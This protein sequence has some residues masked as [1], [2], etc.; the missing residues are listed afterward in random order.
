LWETP[1]ALPS[2]PRTWWAWIRCCMW[3]TMCMTDPPDDEK[4][5]IFQ[6]PEFIKKMLEKGYL[7]EKTRQGF[8]KKSKDADGKRV[9]LSLDYKSLDY[10]P[11]EKVKIASLEAAKNASGVGNKIKALYYAKDQAGEFTFKTLS[12]TLIYAATAFLKLPMTLSM[13]IMP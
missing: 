1:K 3:P 9:I 4:R 12:E 10:T 6:A 8:Y 2:G 13:W 7:G 5:E 11:Q